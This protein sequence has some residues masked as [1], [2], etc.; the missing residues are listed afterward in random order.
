[1]RKNL[2]ECLKLNPFKKIFCQKSTSLLPV[3]SAV[4]GFD[5][6]QLQ[7]YYPEFINYYKNC[8]LKTKQWF[9]KNAKKDWVYCD[10]GANVGIYS[11]LFSLLSPSGFVYAFEPTSTVQMLNRNLSAYGLSNVEVIQKALGKV[12]G[13]TQENLYRIWGKPPEKC[14]VDFI[15]LD[16]FFASRRISRLDCI[17]IDVDSYDLDVLEG[18][19]R[20]LKKFNPFVIV[21]LN[22]AL[23]LRGRSNS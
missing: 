14:D 19:L 22:H 12:S 1:M 17:K 15:T 9:V 18:A 21:E 23:A 20:T 2:I 3:Q 8:E 16:K 6:I 4:P 11:I 7:D 5:S 10:A 13:Q